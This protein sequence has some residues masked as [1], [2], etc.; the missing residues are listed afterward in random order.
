M[1]QALKER[2]EWREKYV[3]VRRILEM[4]QDLPG[5]RE[6]LTQGMKNEWQGIKDGL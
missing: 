6:K 2:D 3:Y 5:V 1:D 4:I